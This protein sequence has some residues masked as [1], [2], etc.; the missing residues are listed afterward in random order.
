MPTPQQRAYAK[1]LDDISKRFDK[2]DDTTIRNIVSLLQDLRK[3]IAGEILS[4]SGFDAFRQFFSFTRRHEHHPERGKI[5]LARDYP[6]GRWAVH[7]AQK[8]RRTKNR[9]HPL[10]ST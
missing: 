9:S 10:P 1:S 6:S 4:A 5:I 2:L 8:K 7:S 3:N